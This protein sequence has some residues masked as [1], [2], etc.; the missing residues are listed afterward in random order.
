M[1]NSSIDPAIASVKKQMIP[2]LIFSITI[3]LLMLVLPIYMLQIYDRVLTSQN[4]TTLLLLS[5]VAVS[6]VAIGSLVT[7][8]RSRLAA[9]LSMQVA[10]K[11]ENVTFDLSMKQRLETPSAPN[12]FV[13]NL[14]MIRDFIGGGSMLRLFDI[15]WTPLFLLVTYFL[16]PLTGLVATTFAAVILLIDWAAARNAIGRDKAY[17]EANRKADKLLS[18]GLGQAEEVWVM[19]MADGVRSQWHR[20][21]VDALSE[22][23][24]TTDAKSSFDAARRFIQQTAQMAMLGVGAF[25]AV[26]E[27]ITAGAIVAG[28]IICARALMPINGIT[29]SWRRYRDIRHIF[30]DLGDAAK[31][32]TRVSQRQALVD[33]DMQLKVSDLAVDLGEDLSPVIRQLNFTMHPGEGLSIVGAGGTGKSLLIRTLMGAKRPAQGQ[34][35]MSGL[36]LH[37][38][39][40][41]RCGQLVGYVSEKP[42]LFEGTL[43]QNLA[44]FGDATIEDLDCAV[45]LAG[46]T[47]FLQQL[48]Q[49]YDTPIADVIRQLSPI[50]RR[51]VAFAR[52]LYGNPVLLFLD[53]IDD[54]LDQDELQMLV[55]AIQLCKE[56]G[57]IVILATNRGQIVQQLDRVLILTK[58][59]VERFCNVQDLA[60]QTQAIS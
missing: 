50:H 57:R 14:D 6:F 13:G 11:L 16:H 34:V 23:A 40:A 42:S 38:L 53:Q 8:Y 59:G 20:R 60:P 45:E 54:G 35:T 51:F 56:S 9:R 33:V 5:V 46:L 2:L 48:P 26:Q 25:L 52:A 27:E 44:R 15:P 10:T 31:D 24:T 12:K 17:Q 37:D 7:H 36:S 41:D 21:R 49:G 47:P 1:I 18:W 32:E 30:A 58:R 4:L 3:N 39:T 22:L 28:S 19:N 43:G 29:Q 55:R